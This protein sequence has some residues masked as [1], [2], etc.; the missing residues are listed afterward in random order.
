[1]AGFSWLLIIAI[2]ENLHNKTSL[3]E[4]LFAFRHIKDLW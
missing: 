2:Q 4:Q 3:H 1:M